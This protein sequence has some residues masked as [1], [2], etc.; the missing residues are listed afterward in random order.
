MVQKVS[1]IV[2]E[3]SKTELSKFG[4]FKKLS[5]KM[6]DTITELFEGSS[7]FSNSF[8]EKVETK[9]QDICYKNNINE[10]DVINYINNQ[11]REIE[12]KGE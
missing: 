9:I 1:N 7:T 4:E 5:P 8:M 3:W 12:D 11:S 10:S 6:K 2:A